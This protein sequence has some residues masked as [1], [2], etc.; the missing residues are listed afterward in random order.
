MTKHTPEPWPE[1]GKIFGKGVL[2]ICPSPHDGGV[3][4]FIPNRARIHQCVNACAGINPEAVKDLVKALEAFIETGDGHDD[5]EDE[6]PAARA[7]LAKAKL[8]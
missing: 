4:E 2:Y 6:W 7:A 3:F 1:D 8:L 5:F